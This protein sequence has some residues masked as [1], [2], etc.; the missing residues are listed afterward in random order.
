MDFLQSQTC[1]NLARSF[2][3]ESQARNRYTVYALQARKE[4]QEYLARLFEQTADNEK[5]HAQEFL[6]MLV[7]LAGGPVHNLDIDAGYPYDLGNTAENLQF[8]AQGEDQEH[9]EVYPAFARTAREEGFAD[10][11][12]LWENIAPIEGLHH[13]V[14]EEARK[15][16]TGKTLYKKEQPV[17]WR[18]L[19]CGYILEAAE[20]W[21]TCPV[22]HKDQGW[23]DGCVDDKLAP[24]R[25][26]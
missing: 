22:C 13:N 7:K 21:Q 18:C 8:A 19:N 1:Q 23:A 25:K 20:P 4:K 9:R 11:A 5:V 24:Q 17:V 14:F 10:A 12:A 26:K 6:E 15:Q 2:A 16:Y 3:G